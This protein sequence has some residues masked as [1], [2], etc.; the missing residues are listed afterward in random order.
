MPHNHKVDVPGRISH[1]ST[2][3][4]NW[5]LGHY[6]S[7]WNVS[8]FSSCT[9][10]EIPIEVQDSGSVVYEREYMQGVLIKER[11]M[12]KPVLNKNIKHGRKT[13][14]AKMKSDMDKYEGHK[15]HNFRSKW[16]FVFNLLRRRKRPSRVSPMESWPIIITG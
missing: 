16:S 4:E 11:I 3:L 10:D 6:V 12:K 1:R 14:E 15:S 8:C 7:S 5:S 9:C 2:S 13:K